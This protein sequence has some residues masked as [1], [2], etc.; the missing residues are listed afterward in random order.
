MTLV[1]RPVTSQS[2]ARSRSTIRSRSVGGASNRASKRARAPPD[3][4]ND[5]DLEPIEREDVAASAGGLHF[6]L[7][8]IEHAMQD[9]QRLTRAGWRHSLRGI[10]ERARDHRFELAGLAEDV[11]RAS[12]LINPA[13]AAAVTISPATGA[14]AVPP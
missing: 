7:H 5:R 4:S 12:Y 3:G 11:H 9:L 1:V 2:A 8:R 14:A 10:V 13:A 6:G